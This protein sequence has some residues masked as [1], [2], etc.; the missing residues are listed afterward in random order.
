MILTH[1]DTKI[2]LTPH[3]LR[4]SATSIDTYLR[5]ARVPHIAVGRHRGRGQQDRLHRPDTE[6]LGSEGGYD[7]TRAETINGL[8]KTELI[9]KRGPWKSVDSLEWG[10]WFNHQRLLEPIGNRPPAELDALYEQSQAGISVA[11]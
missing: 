10:T 3:K 7:N 2:F 11:A 8:N 9:H 4:Y 5:L 6:Q 1:M